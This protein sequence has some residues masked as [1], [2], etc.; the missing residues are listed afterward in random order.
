MPEQMY[1][2]VLPFMI[3][4]QTLFCPLLLM[5]MQ[6]VGRVGYVKILTNMLHAVNYMQD[7]VTKNVD[8]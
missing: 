8:K 6:P 3:T 4:L 2:T 5:I 7:L 1:N